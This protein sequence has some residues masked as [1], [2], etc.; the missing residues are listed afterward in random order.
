MPDSRALRKNLGQV[1]NRLV[2][3]AFLSAT[4]GSTVRTSL[5][6]RTWRVSSRYTVS[7]GMVR[8][9]TQGRAL[10]ARG[11]ILEA[12]CRSVLMT[13]GATPRIPKDGH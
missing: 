6:V 11:L 5:A 10:A 8:L 9:E 2:R 12:V 1:R 4:A 7:Y 13:E 3:R